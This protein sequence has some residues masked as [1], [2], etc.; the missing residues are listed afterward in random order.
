MKLGIVTGM[1]FEADIARQAADTTNL[2]LRGEPGAAQRDTAIQRGD[3]RIKNSGLLHPS[4]LRNDGQVLIACNG[5]GPD[6]ATTAALSLIEREAKCLISFGIAG[7]LDP[8]LHS[9]D[10]I[11]PS[12]I[13]T[14]ADAFNASHKLINKIQKNTQNIDNNIFSLNEIIASATDKT[15]LFKRTGAVAVDMESG[16]VAQIAHDNHVPFIALRVIADPATQALPHSAEAGARADGSVAVW[17]V[18]GALLKRPWELPDLIR[19]GRQT[20]TAKRALSH[21]ALLSLPLLLLGEE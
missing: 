5:P 8:S 14:D 20:A 9:G 17:P 4:G 10:V 6:A 19:L 2:S 18:I 3:P 1:Q 13:K 7:A 11:V 12:T 21:L 16:A 15:A